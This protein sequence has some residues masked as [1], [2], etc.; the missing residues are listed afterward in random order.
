MAIVKI[1]I[2][3]SVNIG[4]YAKATDSYLL[5]SGEATKKDAE[6]MEDVLDVETHRVLNQDSRVT[7][8]FVVG[9][10]NGLL[11]SSFLDEG[12]VDGFD[13]G[14]VVEVL[15]SR[16]SAV[17]NLILANDSGALVSPNLS[18]DERRSIA[19]VLDTEVVE[20][21]LNDAD[22]LGS[23]AVANNKGALVTPY[24]EDEEM[25]LLESV[26]DVEAMRGTINGGEK[27]IASGLLATGRGALTGKF[28][29][30]TELM[31]I[32]QALKVP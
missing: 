8:P 28:T 23:L 17:G 32:G 27:F 11:L 14:L 20:G 4:N 21:R 3:G 30:G 31:R 24:A 26:L 25:Q 9:N 22:Y 10:R 6:R 5:L 18:Q 12:D 1:E 13:D 19:D 29:D 2:L 15:D 16:Y 7:A